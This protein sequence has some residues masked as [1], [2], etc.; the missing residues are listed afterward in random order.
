[1]RLKEGVGGGVLTEAGERE[2]Q[3]YLYAGTEIGDAQVEGLSC[4]DTRQTLV[5][6]VPG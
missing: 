1:M 4:V 5:E 6:G 3:E 2:A